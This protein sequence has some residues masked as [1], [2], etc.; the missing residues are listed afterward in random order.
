[1]RLNI[2]IFAFERDVRLLLLF[3]FVLC[4]HYFVLALVAFFRN[5]LL[6]ARIRLRHHRWSCLCI[7]SESGHV[8]CVNSL[9]IYI[10]CG[11]SPPRSQHV[12][13]VHSLSSS[14]V[15]FTCVCVCVCTVFAPLSSIMSRTI[16]FSLN[17]LLYARRAAW[18]GT[19]HRTTTRHCTLHR[20]AVCSTVTAVTMRYRSSVYTI[21]PRTLHTK[22][23]TN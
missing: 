7:L 9:Q 23:A 3:W 10:R 16:N 13:I 8:K 18:H 12:R 6:R 1:M 19:W 17:P 14:F 11:F 4:V 2:H 5:L 21:T 15:S 20:R 22:D